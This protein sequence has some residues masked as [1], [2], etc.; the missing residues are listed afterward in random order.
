MRYKGRKPLPMQIAVVGCWWGAMAISAF[1]YGAYLTA[2]KG[3][4]ATENVGFAI[5]PI[6]LI[7]AGLAQFLLFWKAKHLP[8]VE[9]PEESG[10]AQ[11]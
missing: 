10:E 9:E 5:Y 1:F 3:P 2:T 7:A 4:E 8:D 11:E 6:M